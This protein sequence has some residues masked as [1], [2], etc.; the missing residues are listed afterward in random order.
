M[1]IIKY[2]LCVIGIFCVTHSIAQKPL[3]NNFIKI[4]GF[5]GVLHP[6]VTLSSEETAVNFRDYYTVGFPFGVNFWKTSNTAFSIEIIPII[7]SVNG[8]SKMNN[9][10]FHPGLV[11]D[12]GNGFRISARAAFETAGRYG[13]TPVFTKTIYKA[14]SNSYFIA[15]GL[16]VRFGNDIPGS[17]GSALQIGTAF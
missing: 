16:P 5:F 14:K 2:L 17:I 10:L 4:T 12:V 15:L 1:R 6:L 7:K 9:V 13:F 8:S 3:P 11:F